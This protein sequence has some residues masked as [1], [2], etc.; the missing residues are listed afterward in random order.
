MPTTG[1]EVFDHTMLNLDNPILK[2]VYILLRNE[3][4]FWGFMLT[5]RETQRI[6]NSMNIS[7]IEFIAYYYILL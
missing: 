6:H 3:F 1:I 7:K 5:L 2:T 4:N